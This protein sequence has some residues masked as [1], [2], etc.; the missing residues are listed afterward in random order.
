MWI[1]DLL[2]SLPMGQSPSALA[3]Q[4]LGHLP[5]SIDRLHPT[6]VLMDI[7]C[8]LYC[9]KK[10]LLLGNLN[11]DFNFSPRSIKMLAVRQLHRRLFP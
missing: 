6:V 11:P 1:C 7:A 10:A 4:A 8:D 3:L 5:P 9:I 2:L